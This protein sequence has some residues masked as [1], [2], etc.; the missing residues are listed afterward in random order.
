MMPEPGSE[1]LPA[2]DPFE[3]LPPHR[4]LAELA[5]KTRHVIEKSLELKGS[6]APGTR[7]ALRVLLRSMNAY[8]SA[9]M[10]GEGI[11]PRNIERALAADFSAKPEV[12]RRQR[13][14]LAHIEAEQELAAKL[15]DE[16]AEAFA[17][18][19]S[20]LVEAHAA[21]YRRLTPADR[22]TDEGVVVEPGVLRSREVAAGRQLPPTHASVPAFLKRMDEFYPKVNGLDSILYGVACAHQRA[23]WIRPFPDGNGR[24]C[25]L[26]TQAALFRMTGGLWS[27][28]RGLASQREQY[29]AMLRMAG[30]PRPGDADGRRNLSERGLFRWCEFFINLALEQVSFMHRLL[31][32]HEWRE[33]IETLVLVRSGSRQYAN[34]GRAAALALHHVLVAGPITRGDFMSLLGMPGR[35]ASRVLGQLLKDG[36]LSSPGPRG[37]VSFNFPLNALNLLLPNLYPEASAPDTDG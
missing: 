24:A 29:D 7:N 26:Q 4:Q 34:D 5:E 1:A 14:A 19:S 30:L 36:L 35:T 3:P 6:V 9:R 31:A 17:L 12:A 8:D 20:F 18:R 33:R 22:T 11:H 37:P 2:N 28:N 27:V 16:R 32:L 25:R 23:A 15:P 13:I 10:D 21:L